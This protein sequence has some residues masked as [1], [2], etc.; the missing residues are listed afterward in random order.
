MMS[1]LA[2]NIALAAIALTTIVGLLAASVATAH[3]DRGVTLVRRRRTQP[4]LRRVS[5][6]A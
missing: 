3:S 1:I 2:V 6:A 4:A 5:I